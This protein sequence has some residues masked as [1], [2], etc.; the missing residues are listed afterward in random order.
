MPNIPARFIF[1]S[2][3]SH[4]PSQSRAAPSEQGEL[5][6][7]NGAH[8][9]ER[10]PPRSSGSA[11]AALTPAHGGKAI[12]QVAPSHLGR[13]R[14]KARPCHGG[15][16]P[17]GRRAAPPRRRARRAGAAPAA[18]TCRRPAG[19]GDLLLRGRGCRRRA[20]RGVPRRG[21]C[22]R[23]ASEPRP[24]SRCSSRQ[25]R[26]AVRPRSAVRGR[27][28]WEW[29]GEREKARLGAIPRC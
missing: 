4:H 13:G 11:T 9:R 14:G 15:P 20:R 24:R 3:H 29:P 26:A 18:G 25:R 1:S 22:G 8:L 27:A 6:W 28:G 23:E 12:P 21:C 17:G 16:G 7:G 19:S 10:R 2:S 5:T